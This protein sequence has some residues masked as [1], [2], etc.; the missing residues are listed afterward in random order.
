MSQKGKSELNDLLSAAVELV[1]VASWRGDN[2]LSHPSDDPK[3]WSARMQTA[4]HRL[5]ASVEHNAPRMIEKE[6]Q[7][8]REWEKQ[9]TKDRIKP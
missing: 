8:M 5:Y 4:W 6:H 3:L 2:E 7:A 9:Q 1:A